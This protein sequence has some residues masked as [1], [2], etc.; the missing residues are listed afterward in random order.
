MT[1]NPIIFIIFNRPEHTRRSFEAIRAQRPAKLLIIADG[2]RIEKQNDI[3]KCAETRQVVAN[4][5][6][7]CEVLRD[8]S[9]INLGCKVR[10]SS[11]LNWAF[12]QVEQAIVLEDDCIPNPDFFRYCDELLAHYKDNQSVWVITGNNFQNGTRRGDAAYYYSKYNHCWGWATWR[13]AWSQYDVDM[14]FWPKWAD[15]AD[16]KNRF[17][18]ARERK[19]WEN[20][21]NQVKKGNIDT[22]DYQ[23]TATVW[24]NKG[25]TA[26]PNVNLVTNIGYGPDATHTVTSKDQEGIPSEALG[27]LTHPTQV[28]VDL[29]ADDYVFKNMFRGPN[30]V[31]K[32]FHHLKH[33]WK[34]AVHAI[35]K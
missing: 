23:W 6:W 11:G 26:T 33:R 8:Y 3:L 10:V 34:R 28:R 14:P 13:R 17:V 4:I 9:E 29:E 30:I 31:I 19:T 25:L 21:F 12:T 16:W 15:T 7:P 24:Y 2:P 27:K 20:I 22:W 1:N 18:T 35:F 32:I 5:D